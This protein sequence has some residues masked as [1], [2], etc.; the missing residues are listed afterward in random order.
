MKKKN[1][2]KIILI[3]LLDITLIAL[4]VLSSYY[5]VYLMPHK[6]LS[7]AKAAFIEQPLSNEDHKGLDAGSNVKTDWQ[8]KFKDKFSDEI[9]NTQNTYK[10][11]NI[12]ITI[13]KSNLNATKTIIEPKS[14]LP[15]INKDNSLSKK[16][17]ISSSG[18]NLQNSAT[19]Y[20]ADIYL[21]NLNCFKTHFAEDAY[22]TGYSEKLIDISTRKNAILAIN[23]DSYSNNKK[24][25]FSGPLI[26]NG[27]VYRSEPTK[28][29]I[30]VLFKDGSMKT[31]DGTEFDE[32][33]LS[34]DDIYQTWVFGPSL[35]DENGK[36][37][38]DFN[39][40]AYIKQ[41]HPRTSIGYYEPGHYC[42]IVVDGRNM[43]FSR[44]MYLE[45]L[46]KIFESLG[47]KAAYNL[48]GGH[49]SYMEYKNEYINTPV[50]PNNKITDGIFI[51]EAN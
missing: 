39:T 4:L 20:I 35:L 40:S 23:G 37:A 22:G 27:V 8:Y 9:I 19:Y 1:I 2:I 25:N 16:S 47:C 46:A 32:A 43:D 24:K 11:S 51:E 17:T 38:K 7:E 30:C 29:D 28:S 18:S 50:N 33:S 14:N 6:E 49:C 31:Y 15:T 44:G 36:A 42:L 3:A 26:R 12:S 21:G 48:D 34:E 10:S 45:E 41:N 13:T 5:F